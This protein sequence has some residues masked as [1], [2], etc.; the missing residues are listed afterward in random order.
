[1][2]Q[3][4]TPLLS[5]A[6]VVALIPVALWLLRRSGVAGGAVNGA[7]MRTV[8]VLP[9]SGTQRIVTV[10]VGTGEDRRWLVLGVT[11]NS[12]TTLHTLPPQGDAP[13]AGAVPGV[14][15]GFGDLLTRLRSKPPQEPSR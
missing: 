5:F 9:L 14:P 13:T 6:F 7:P 15:P 11:P 2:E 12:I 10:E 3:A 4:L 8:G 1:M